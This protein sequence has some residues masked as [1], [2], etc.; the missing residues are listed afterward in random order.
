[1]AVGSGHEKCNESMVTR[2]YAPKIVGTR[3]PNR[4]GQQEPTRRSSMT[5]W[6]LQPPLLEV[7]DF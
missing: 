3:S 7:M 5:V 2:L 6:I 4:R 1:M